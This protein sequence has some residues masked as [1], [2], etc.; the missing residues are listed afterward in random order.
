MYFVAG[1][2][3]ELDESKF[4]R[5]GNSIVFY[6]RYEEELPASLCFCNGENSKTEV[7]NLPENLLNAFI[8]VEDKRFYSHRG[9]DL[10]ALFRAAKNNLKSKSFK[11]GGS[12][13]TQ[14][15]I[16]NTHLSGEKT[17]LRK[18]RE[19]K[20]TLQAEKRF[21]KK[22]ILSYYL[23]TIYFG[24]SR[25][26]VQSASLNYF[27]KSAS[28]L[29]L[30][31]CAALSATVKSPAYYNPRT[32]EGNKRKDL[33]LKLMREQNLISKAEFCKFYGTKVDICENANESETQ[34]FSAALQEVYSK[35]KLSPY[36]QKTIKIYTFFDKN[37]HE[38]LK[39]RLADYK[40]EAAACLIGTRGEI[41]AETGNAELKRSPASAIKPLL[42]YA[43]AL[44]SK[45]VTLATKILNERTDFSGYSPQN[46][47]DEYGGYVS[48]K[49]AI[50]KSLNVPAVKVLN[51]LS[52]KKA[53]EAALKA[54]VKITDL[55][56]ASALGAIGEGIS[57]TDLCAAYSVFKND[58]IYYTPKR[59]KSAKIGDKKI[60]SA[61]FN[62]TRAFSAGTAEL[63]NEALSECAKSGTARA[64]CEKSYDVCAKTGTN[65]D[66]NGNDDALCAAYTSEHSLVIRFSALGDKK[67]DNRI[68]GGYAAKYVSNVFDDIYF[69]HT[70]ADFKNS[71]EIVKVKICKAAYEDGK[72]LLADDNAP[73]KYNLEFGF[74]KGSEPKEKSAEFSQ[75]EILECELSTDNGKVTLCINR[76]KFVRCKI[77]R[78]GDGGSKIIAEISG[79]QKTFV[80]EPE[81]FGSYS[82]SIIPY[83]VNPSGEIIYGEEVCAGNVI[84]YDKFAESEWWKE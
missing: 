75:P 49:D 56:L 80:D 71:G 2:G 10:R 53:A 84:L 38:S 77:V 35:A 34:Y 68:T 52:T 20:L 58:G 21:S 59:V 81:N 39:N 74:L 66:K 79:D 8:A 82:Y 24:E 13:I 12:T 72:I 7:E 15:L 17:I 47:G 6:D 62:E 31:E 44:E 26:G 30:N 50:K 40:S 73:E 16:K 41:L 78:S 19:L 28:E 70:P 61:Q 23:S 76:K 29:D 55:S 83:S 37:A 65:G 60:Y 45:T 32:T 14:Q 11:E 42:V 57:V 33:V 1:A 4:S 46:Y 25:Y 27:G 64:L 36:E 3:Y 54:G 69:N 67:L 5:D 43:P 63:I 22:Q 18:L 48:V 9:V 51:L